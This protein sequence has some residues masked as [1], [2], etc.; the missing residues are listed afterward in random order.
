MLGDYKD[1]S[2][3]KDQCGYTIDD[4]WFPRVTKIV[5]I[6]AKP[7]LL[8][9]YGEAKSYRA[10]ND[11]TE[12]SAKEGTAIHEAVEAIMLGKEPEVAAAIAPAIKSF[13][14]FYEKNKIHVTPECV[15]RRIVNVDHR[16]AGTVDAIAMIGGKLGV[17]DIKTSQAIYRDYSLQTSA[18]MD[19]LKNEF[20]NLQTRWILK[21]DQIQ[22]CKHCQARRRIK[23]GKETIK[24]DWR[25]TFARNCPH[26]WSEMFGDIELQEF[27]YWQND[28][29]AFLGAKRLW[30]WE[31]ESWLKRVGYLI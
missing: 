1:I 3:F 18:Y 20:E 4:A 25:N 8:Y 28:F 23:G 16:Y 9:Y 12:R 22:L 26:E 7:A 15:E 24:T 11:A 29:E 14:E 17:L 21:I 6:K 5:G 10:A 2:E 30:E 19:A 27:P 31:N 13:R